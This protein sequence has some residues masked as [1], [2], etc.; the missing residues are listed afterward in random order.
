MK[1]LETLGDA[2][3][4]ENKTMLYILG[5]RMDIFQ[6]ASTCGPTHNQVWAWPNPNCGIQP[7]MKPRDPTESPGSDEVTAASARQADN[8]DEGGKASG[9]RRHA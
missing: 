7:G 4:K 5:R 9:E 8:D 3:M 6:E 1:I 2:L